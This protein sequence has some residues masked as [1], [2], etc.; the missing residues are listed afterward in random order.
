MKLRAIDFKALWQMIET[1]GNQEQWKAFESFP[2]PVNCLEPTGKKCP[3]GG[4]VY[5]RTYGYLILK[6]RLK[7]SVRGGV[8]RF[9]VY[10]GETT[11]PI[12]L[13]KYFQSN[14]WKYS[15]NKQFGTNL[16]TMLLACDKIDFPNQDWNRT[17]TES[18]D[19][20]YRLHM[21]RQTKKYLNA[22]NRLTDYR[23]HQ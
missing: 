19:G 7:P 10:T 2:V 8:C 21:E 4:N 12:S 14:H 16:E 22:M 6:I 3:K 13:A 23:K 15:E 1:H 18:K 9:E 20:S 17:H 11:K 5:R